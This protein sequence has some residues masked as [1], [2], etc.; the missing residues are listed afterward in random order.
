MAHLFIGLGNPDDKYKNTRHNFGFKVIDAIADSYD[1]KF[2]QERDYHY[3][4]LTLYNDR[5]FLFKPMTYVNNSGVPIAK[6]MHYYKL[7]WYELFLFYDDIDIALGSYKIKFSGSS[8][9]HN[10]LK[11]IISNIRTQAFA[12]MKLGIGP[13]PA[14]TVMAEFVLANFTKDETPKVDAMI[15][16]AKECFSYVCEEGA[17]EVPSLLKDK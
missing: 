2:K 9:G 7:A 8:A 5:V 1:V 3:A 16:K 4:D 17:D 11:S 10:G 15:E 6:F 14:N 13:K 12:R